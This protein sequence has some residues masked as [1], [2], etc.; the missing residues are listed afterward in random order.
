MESRMI[1]FIFIGF[2]F[3]V[4]VLFWLSW[5]REVLRLSEIHPPAIRI[6]PLPSPSNVSIV[7][8]RID[9]VGGYGIRMYSGDDII[10]NDN[11]V[12]YHAE[13]RNARR[14]AH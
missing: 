6:E 14:I 13:V 1:L 2:I 10:I 9:S 8:N 12:V 3:W 11:H 5:K 4:V 7:E